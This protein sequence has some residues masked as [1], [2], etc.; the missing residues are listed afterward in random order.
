MSSMRRLRT[1]RGSW[2]NWLSI[3]LW[4]RDTTGWVAG[5]LGISAGGLHRWVR[6]DRIDRGEIEGIDTTFASKD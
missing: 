2:V 4:R 1:V 5:E 3:R 6:Q